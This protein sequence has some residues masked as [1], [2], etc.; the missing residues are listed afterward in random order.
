MPY[1]TFNN[2]PFNPYRTMQPIKIDK[3]I[4]EQTKSLRAIA[5]GLPT[6]EKNTILNKCARIELLA[7]KTANQMNVGHYRAA[8]AAGKQ[9]IKDDYFNLDHDDIKEMMERKAG[10]FAAMKAGRR[11]SLRNADEF[12]V[13]QMHTTLHQIH[14]DIVRQNLPWIWCKEK[15]RPNP[16]GRP[17]CEYWL[18][19][20]EMEAPAE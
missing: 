12:K 8:Q 14:R 20:K 5:A 11:I 19:P 1:F 2:N 18:I 9:I 10:V 6:R 7:K 4:A 15:V 13:S 16:D 17:F 3:R